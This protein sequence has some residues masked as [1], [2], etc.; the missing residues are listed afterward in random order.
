MN[1][2]VSSVKRI[3]GVDPGLSGGWALLD[4]AGK[5]ITLANFPTRTVKKHGKTSTQLDGPQ[6][7]FDFDCAKPTHAFVE[8]VSSRPRQAGQFQFGVNAG[9]IH[10]ILF[11]QGIEP[12]LV[13]SAAWKGM[14]GIKRGEDQT[15]RDMKTQSRVVATKLFPA[16]AASFARVK[17]DGVAEAALIALYGIYTINQEAM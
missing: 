10:G 9:I 3:L 17:D 13:G 15:K 4:G 2:N 7:A 12:I 6:L 8:A 1:T 5:V 11:A 14:L 16:H